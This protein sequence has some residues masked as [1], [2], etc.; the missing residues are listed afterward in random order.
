[1]TVKATP[2]KIL[3]TAERLFVRNGVDATSLR[4]INTAAGSSQGVLHYHFGNK[5]KLL[6]TLL[7]LRMQPIMEERLS[8]L[9]ALQQ[10]RAAFS[11][12]ALLDVI[13]LPL[14]RRM[15]DGSPAERKAVLLLARLFAENNPV[16]QKVSDRYFKKSGT[17]M[18]QQLHR[19]LP[20]LSPAQLEIRLGIA[21]TAIF[22]TIPA[23]N[24]P[25]RHWQHSL[26]Q[27]KI[28]AWELVDEL[29]GFLAKGF[30]A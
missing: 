28:P 26:Q 10:A 18:F 20:K 16:H 22:S 14:A 8:M 3:N 17:E 5:D 23:I 13:A 2:Q 30:E 6:E 4:A 21:T 7:E 24:R 19:G 12:R 15:I 27:Q 29:L 25:H 9:A 1:M 11:V